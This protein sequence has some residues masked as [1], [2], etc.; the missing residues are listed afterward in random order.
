M[1]ERGRGRDRRTDR[2][3]K[4]QE[5]TVLGPRPREA[6]ET[7]AKRNSRA[8]QRTG[9][10]G[11][12]RRLEGWPGAGGP[13]RRVPG[14]QRPPTDAGPA[15]GVPL[16]AGFAVTAV[17]A[18]EVVAHL[19]RAALVHT[20]LTL[21]HVCQG[22]RAGHPEAR[23]LPWPGPPVGQGTREAPG[24]A[25]GGQG[26]GWPHPHTWSHPGWHGSRAHRAAGSSGTCRSPQC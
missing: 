21:I 13:H 11:R 6:E 2:H 14:H 26:G 12:R 19:A 5:S 1:S 15:E 24:W 16:E 17:G 18:R 3:R 4:R 20:R 10:A 23:V 25:E 8:R 9:P 7:G 22:R